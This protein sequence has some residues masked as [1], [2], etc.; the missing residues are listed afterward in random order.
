MNQFRQFEICCD[1]SIKTFP[2]GRTFGCAG[3]IL[4]GENKESFQIIPDCTNNKAELMAMYLAVK[5]A[6][7]LTMLYGK[8]DITIYADSKITVYG[9]KVWM[10]DW[11]KSMDERGVMY[12][13]ENKPVKNQHL[14]LM[15][16]SYIIINNLR[17]KIR[18]QKGHVKLTPGKL[19]MANRVFYESNGYYLDQDSIYRI[20]LYNS[21]IDK[22]T[23]NLLQN[24]NT[25]DYPYRKEETDLAMMCRYTIP[26]DYKKYIL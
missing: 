24:V 25:N 9:L 1:A 19:A 7:E 13:Y 2:N 23:R 16:I 5:M 21:I 14:Y 18:H 17:I 11:L 4:I 6:H 8:C 12:N 20:S 15:I 10:D 26:D 3:A 22:D